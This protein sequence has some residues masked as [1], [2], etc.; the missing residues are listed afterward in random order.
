MRKGKNKKALKPSQRES[1][2][3]FSSRYG[4][5]LSFEDKHKI[6]KVIGYFVV[7][8]CIIILIYAGFFFTD[9]FIKFTEIPPQQSSINPEATLQWISYHTI[10]G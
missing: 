5:G 3:A 6:K 2:T 4:S 8:I 7:A 1:I 9:L 10:Q